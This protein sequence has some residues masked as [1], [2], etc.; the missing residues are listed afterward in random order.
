MT[1]CQDINQK[2]MHINKLISSVLLCVCSLTYAWA[3]GFVM[4]EVSDPVIP[5]RTVSVVDFGGVADGVHN[6]SSAFAVAIDKLAHNGGGH[7]VVP[8]GIWLTGPI[9]LKSNID[10]HLEKGAIILFDSDRDLYPVIDIPFEG[11][12]NRRCK[13]Q[14]YAY[15]C[16]NISIT[17]EGIIDGNGEQWRKV[18]KHLVSPDH[19]KKLVASGGCLDEKGEV[20]YPDE[21]YRYRETVKGVKYDEEYIKSFLRPVLL[22]FQNCENVL[23]DGCTFQNS[24]SWNLHPVYCRNLT[25]RNITVRNPHYSANGDGLDIDACE[26]VLVLNSTF[27]CGDDAICVK[28]GKDEDGRRHGIPTKNLFVEGCTVFHGHGGI[29]IGSEM[30]GGVENVLVRDCCFL[31]TDVGI[32]LK[33]R[34]GRGGVVKGI[35]IENIYMTEIKGDA[36]QFDMFYF[37]KSKTDPPMPEPVTEKTPK[38]SSVYIKNVTCIGARRAM[39]FNGLPEMPVDDIRIENC[40]IVSEKGMEFRRVSNVILKDVEVISSVGENLI[41]EDTDNFMIK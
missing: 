41:K 29:V 8:A 33:T 38:L 39:Y 19:W 35:F 31:G 21:G 7:L 36:I 13:S 30:S 23:L 6:N 4:P 37:Y 3:D 5:Q 26:N 10:L 12:D 32:R 9:E 15:G 34:R 18:K 22:T 24:P 40:R 14:L 20:W 1:G 27:D 25:V 28:S 11:T 16:R 17:G 2:C